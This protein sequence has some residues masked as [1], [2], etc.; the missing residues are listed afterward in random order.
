MNEVIEAQAFHIIL[1]K[2]S[3]EKEQASRLD[4]GVVSCKFGNM[5]ELYHSGYNSYFPN[6]TYGTVQAYFT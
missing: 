6:S 5:E 4:N 1:K 3:C 2:K